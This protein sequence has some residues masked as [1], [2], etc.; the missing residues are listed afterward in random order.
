MGQIANSVQFFLGTADDDAHRYLK[1][2]TFESLE[3]LK[4]LMED[5][6]VLRSKRLAQHA[7][8]MN[9]LR[10]VH[11]DEVAERTRNEHSRLFQSR[12]GYTTASIREIAQKGGLEP[13]LAEASKGDQDE[14]SSSSSSVNIMLPRSLVLNR[15]MAQVLFEAGLVSSRSQGDRLCASNGAYIG[16]ISDS[17]K[18]KGLKWRPV[19]ELERRHVGNLVIEGD[20]LCLRAGKTKVRVIMVISD[21][22]FEARGLTAPGWKMRKDKEGG[23]PT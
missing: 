8:A 13:S 7:L 15:T 4:Q 14:A 20:I 21:E 1:L 16:V 3:T 22:D 5:H 17:D 10:L 18:D 12:V 19:G 11:G 6:D 23:D 2:F 9:V